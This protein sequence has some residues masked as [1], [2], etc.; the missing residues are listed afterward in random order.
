MQIALLLGLYISAVLAGMSVVCG[1]WAAVEN[2]EK[3][4]ARQGLRTLVF[5]LASLFCLVALAC[6]I[7]WGE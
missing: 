7:S 6:I 1:A 5:G 3:E 2:D 4:E